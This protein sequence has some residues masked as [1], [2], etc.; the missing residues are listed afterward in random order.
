MTILY[1]YCPLVPRPVLPVVDAL[2]SPHSLIQLI[3]RSFLH[4][5]HQ[6]H[7]RWLESVR[8][9]FIRHILHPRGNDENSSYRLT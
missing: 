1:K 6:K 8:I 7:F 3:A 4:F 2:L 9:A 5:F